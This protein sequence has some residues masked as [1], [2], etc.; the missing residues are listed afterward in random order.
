MGFSEQAA[1]ENTSAIVFWLDSIFL[2]SSVL[3]TLTLTHNGLLAR[4]GPP[5]TA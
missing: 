4:R 1:F 2:N 5:Y 3:I